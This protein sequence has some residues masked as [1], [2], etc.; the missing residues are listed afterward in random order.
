MG[1]WEKWPKVSVG[2]W[3]DG[4]LGLTIELPKGPGQVYRENQYVSDVYYRFDVREE[5]GELTRIWGYVEIAGGIAGQFRYG[6]EL[7][8]HLDDGR[9]IEIIIKT[10]NFNSGEYL[11]AGKS[12]EEDANAAKTRYR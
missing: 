10:F 2:S 11:F 12:V 7:T 4:K 6:E 9:P 1:K 3:F 8:L 5:V